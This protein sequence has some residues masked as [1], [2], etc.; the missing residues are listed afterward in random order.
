MPDL[1]DLRKLIHDHEEKDT[2]LTVDVELCLKT[3]L[4]DE[5]IDLQSK[6]AEAASTF[7]YGT[8]G[9]MASPD[10]S[11]DPIVAALDEDVA[12]K[13]AEVD[14]ATIVVHFKALTEPKY[15]QVLRDSPPM[16]DESSTVDEAT[17]LATLT[18]RCYRG[19]NWGGQ[20]FTA[21]D[22]PWTELRDRLSF[23][24]V[25]P[26]HGEVFA[27][28]RRDKSRRPLSS[29]RSGTNRRT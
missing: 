3:W 15:R 10:P 17:F 16:N 11:D 14:A 26:I 2:G 27:I 8:E 6:R 12:T 18:E 22:L 5:L 13:Q 28:N 19:V 23:G 4:V 25:D 1:S 21:S 20:E 29:G 24:E 9:S 7:L